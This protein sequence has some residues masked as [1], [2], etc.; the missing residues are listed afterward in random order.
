MIVQHD[1]D[2]PARPQIPSLV[3]EMDVE[4]DIG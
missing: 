4:E 1:I 3:I 2:T